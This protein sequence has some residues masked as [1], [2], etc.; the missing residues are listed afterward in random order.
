MVAVKYNWGIFSPGKNDKIFS[1][2]R[3]IVLDKVFPD[4]VQE[5]TENQ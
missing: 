1:S 4:K 2:W 3:I 5:N